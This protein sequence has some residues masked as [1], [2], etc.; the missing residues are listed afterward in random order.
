MK[1]TFTLPSGRRIRVAS[2]RRYVVVVDPIPSFAP[3]VVYRT[4]DRT[5]A[6]GDARRRR[7][8]QIID[9]ATGE[10]VLK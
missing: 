10:V 3:H 1:G 9:T 2:Q 7:Q 8:A 6:I 4:D 5:R